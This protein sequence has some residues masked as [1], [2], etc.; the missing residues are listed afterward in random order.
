MQ[1]LSIKNIFQVDFIFVLMLNLKWKSSS[2][3]N[4]DLGASFPVCKYS[5]ENMILA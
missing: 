1:V 4:F 2:S 3:H 5:R